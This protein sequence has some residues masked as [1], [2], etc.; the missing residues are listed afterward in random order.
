MFQQ[1]KSDPLH[2]VL[3]S[4]AVPCLAQRVLSGR[5]ETVS[6]FIPDLGMKGRGL[7]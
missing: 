2:R 4:M 5:G 6:L 1:H 7:R 3:K